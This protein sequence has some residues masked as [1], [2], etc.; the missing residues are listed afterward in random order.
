[1]FNG[2]NYLDRS[3]NS[4]PRSTKFGLCPNNGYKAIFTMNVHLLNA[5]Y[6]SF[7]EYKRYNPDNNPSQRGCR[8]S[9]S[10]TLQGTSRHS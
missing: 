8:V 10:Y 2:S 6:G 9:S 4:P 7:D 1:M 3:A 5:V